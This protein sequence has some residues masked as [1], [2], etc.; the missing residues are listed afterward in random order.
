VD[1]VHAPFPWGPCHL[2][3]AGNFG[4]R[5]DGCLR[6]VVAIVALEYCGFGSAVKAVAFAPKFWSFP[7]AK[8]PLACVVLRLCNSGGLRAVRTL[9]TANITPR[10]LSV[11]S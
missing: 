7:G 9:Q 3:P 4:H 2:L 5:C 6:V 1:L 11:G 10:G 8:G